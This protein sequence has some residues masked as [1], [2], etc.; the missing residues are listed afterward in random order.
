MNKILDTLFLPQMNQCGFHLGNGGGT[1]NNYFSFAPREGVGKGYY[2]V[3]VMEEMVSITSKH[4]VLY[5][6]SEIIWPQPEY[7]HIGYEHNGKNRLQGY[8]CKEDMFSFILPSMQRVSGIGISLMPEYYS[9]V[10]RQMRNVSESDLAAALLMLDTSPPFYA[11]KEILNQIKHAPVNRRAAGIYY[12]SKI[13]EMLALL[14]QWYDNHNSYTQS[15]VVSDTDKD[16]IKGLMDFIPQTLTKPLSVSQCAQYTCMSKSKLSF[17]FRQMT[18]KTLSGYYQYLRIEKSKE[19]LSVTD[20]SI[21][22]IANMV[23]YRTHAAFSA[24]FRSETGMT[25]RGYRK[26][27]LAIPIGIVRTGHGAIG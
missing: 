7:L 10:L 26:K 17:I 3:F 13:K 9:M 22:Q 6:D 8:L 12:D 25:P 20:K 19:L 15:G 23:G 14:V 27:L 2:N 11:G 1:A 16:A 24:V 21:E 5:K 18:G 4:F